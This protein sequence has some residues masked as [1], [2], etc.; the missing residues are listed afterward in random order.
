MRIS[1][2]RSR[3]IEDLL[4][5]QVIEGT[6][7]IKDFDINGNKSNFISLEAVE[8]KWKIINNNES[9]CIDDIENKI[10]DVYLETN[11]FYTIYNT[12]TKSKLKFYTSDI[13]FKNDSYMINNYLKDK[14]TIGSLDSNKII[15]KHLDDVTATIEQIENSVVL[16]LNTTAKTSVYINKSRVN[17]T[18]LLSNGD[19]IFI[20][21]LKIV[22][23]EEM[24]NEV[25]KYLFVDK[26]AIVNME[27]RNI[28]TAINKEYVEDEEEVEYPLFEEKDYFNKK[29]R[30]VSDIKPLDISI[31]NPPSKI[32]ENKMP[33]LLT[34]G[35]MITMSLTSLLVGYTA[36]DNVLKKDTTWAQAM[37]SLI[38]CFTM[39]AGV[40]IWPVLTRMYTKKMTKKQEAEK[41][42]KYTKYLEEKRKT[43]NDAKSEQEKILCNKYLSTKECSEVILRNYT[44][45][46]ERRPEDEDFLSVNLGSGTYKM[47]INMPIPEKHFQMEEDDLEKKVTELYDEKRMLENVPVVYS[48]IKNYVSGFIG[49]DII[50]HE[51][52][53]QILIQLLAF[54][55]YD[56][57]KIVVLT[58]EENEH[59]FEF[60]KCLPHCFSNDKKMRF[61]A[62]NNNEYKEVCYFLD[63]IYNEKQEKV[64][65]TKKITIDKT[66]LIITNNFKKIRDY[67]VIKKI[68]E[69]KEYFG[70]SLIIADNKITNLPSECNSF[71]KLSVEKGSLQ[72]AKTS[73]QDMISFNVNLKE[74]IDY[75]TCSKIL[76]NMPIDI[77]NE[78]DG[79]IP[80]K[81]G[82]LEMYDVGKVEQLNSSMRWEQNNPT[83]NLQAP[84]GIGK[85]GE[86]IILDAHENFHGPHGLI[87]GSTG[88]GKSELIITFILS[89][90][91]NY[92]PEE[93][94]FI[95]IDYKGGG[96]AGAFDN[97]NMKLP[98]IV[99]TIT[100]LDTNDMNRSFA[101]I[102]SELKRRQEIFNKTRELTGESTVDI[103]KYQRMY[104]EKIVTEPVSHLFIICDEF[105]ELKMQK[106]EFME[107]LIST[108]RIGRGLGIHLILATQKPSGIVDPQIWSNTRFRICMKVQDKVDSNEIIKCSDAAFLSTVGR[109][110]FQVGYNEIFVLGQA[111]WAGTRYL[112]SDKVKKTIDTNI[113]FIDNIGNIIKTSNTK[114][115][116]FV[117]YE[118]LGEE[119]TNIIKYLDKT[120]KEKNIAAKPLWLER[121]SNNI[122]VDNLIKKYNYNKA[123]NII[124]LVIG[125]YDIPSNQE[126]R[127][128]SLNLSESGNTVIYGITGSGKENF[129]T[130]LL[131][132]S[133]LYY[134][135]KE[136]NYYI[137]DF[138]SASLRI[139]EECNMIGDIVN[140]EDADKIENLFKLL[141]S[142]IEQ[143][144]KL[145]Y[146][147][148]GDYLT[149]I[150]NANNLIP[151]IV[152]I[153]NNFELYDESYEKYNER[154]IMLTRECNKYGIYFIVT[155]NTPN[156]LKSKLKQNF[157]QIY[158]LQQNKE[159]D[160]N[161]IFSTNKKVYP[162]NIFG[163]G[164]IKEDNIYEFQTAFASDIDNINNFIKEKISVYN[165]QYPET[166]S[167]IP[168]LP[169]VINYK[170]LDLSS[171]KQTE[172]PIGLNKDTLRI[173]KIDFNKNYIT[174][175]TGQDITIYTKFINNLIYQFL[176]NNLYTITINS[177]NID[178]DENIINSSDY[179]DKRFDDIY[180]KIKNYINECVETYENNNYDRNI[181]DKSKRLVCVILGFSN[182]K[183]KLSDENS[184]EL[185]KLII[186]A[187]ELEVIDF[188]LIDSSSNLKQLEFESWFKKSVNTNNGIWLGNGIATQYNFR[189]NNKL[190]EF[191]KEIPI[192]YC[193]V[194]RNGQAEFVKYIDNID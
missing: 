183:S 16:V 51:Y 179:N 97:N 52:I 177:E 182:F 165:T 135:P 88:S 60:L 82:F 34:I 102:Q 189:I 123:G 111:A 73:E 103:Y 168:V 167:K 37:P 8:G 145:F 48:F 188:I 42:E 56:N 26:T 89:L 32:Q 39:L 79:K 107:Q 178:I 128:L 180:L 143:R 91:V 78:V 172:Y 81:I 190:D 40:I 138:G 36:L 171:L 152:V 174:L 43:I 119:L 1:I 194:I 176:K 106:Y 116:K 13:E 131:Y 137:I 126:Q 96:L 100:N 95:L 28:K 175:I 166:A 153:I 66:Y 49:E 57:L 98:H 70:F 159:E 68:L 29:P 160:Y 149:Y 110:Y 15:Y 104:R 35:P 77:E 33:L 12:T 14:I 121:L 64:Q 94:Q 118:Q 133:M 83:I 125:E 117:V 61:F 18:T 147:Y 54:H 5:P 86:Q 185:D 47:F 161:T 71:I 11:K 101:S 38:I 41:A 90:A 157:G 76:A 169:D 120:A 154:L 6:Y 3:I 141:E 170:D 129:L 67:S 163:R 87:A 9:Y 25:L 20:N 27:Q 130:T 22:Y 112:P 192:N 140:N 24:D 186:K 10:E 155:S 99:G 62:T 59:Y 127:L 151:A 134:S 181:F 162:T 31:D 139:F 146:Q 84:I 105:A 142:S 122:L 184:K 108:A 55:S 7:W 92:S 136:I 191:T 144:K 30:F 173:S 114:T 17:D 164:I 93:V 69:N 45:L 58:D 44:T 63:R 148:N 4:L 74:K 113:E 187:K 21:G 53:K 50:T 115:Q 124:N 65:E 193:Y 75:E 46:W 158:S 85:N 156:G 109:F 19:I 150:K 72:Y 23:Y 2:I 132:S 80:N